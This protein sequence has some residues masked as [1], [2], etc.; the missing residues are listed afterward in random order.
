MSSKLPSADA[1]AD[2]ILTKIDADAGDSITNLK[3]QKLVY[4]VQAWHLALNGSPA[5]SGEIEAWA[6]GPVVRRLYGRFREYGWQAIDPTARRTDPSRVVPRATRELIDEVWDAYGDL[7]G[8]ELEA[9]THSEA[10]WIEAYGDRP[11]GS[12]CTEKIDHD[13]MARFYREML[14]DGEKEGASAS[15]AA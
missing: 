12:R 4:Y 10:P 15:S 9:L 1:I 7:S 13:S 8:S 5:F 11:S 3:I 6:H 2:Y 14:S